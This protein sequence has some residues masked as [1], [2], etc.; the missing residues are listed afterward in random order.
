M[1]RS[2]VDGDAGH[3]FEQ[4]YEAGKNGSCFCLPDIHFSFF[5]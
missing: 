1:I 2:C 3:S 5:R 4:G